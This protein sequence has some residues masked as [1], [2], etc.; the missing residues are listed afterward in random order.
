METKQETVIFTI[1]IGKV[2]SKIIA[3]LPT[4][5][6]QVAVVFSD[7]VSLLMEHDQVC[8]EV[9][10]LNDVVGNLSHLIGRT[11]LNFEESSQSHTDTSGGT[12]WTFYN[13]RT[14][15]GDVTLRWLGES[16]GYYS[17]DVDCRMVNTDWLLES[18]NWVDMITE[19]P[20]GKYSNLDQ[21]PKPC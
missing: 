14:D 17:E 19:K 9:V 13:I 2:I 4:E 11:V 10:V 3:T 18:D 16:N 21:F 20:I 1:T 15:R 12:T 8:C 7:G 6:E 5:P